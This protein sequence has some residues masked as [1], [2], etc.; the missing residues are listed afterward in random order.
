MTTK[1]AQPVLPASRVHTIVDTLFAEDLHAARGRSFANAATGVLRAD[2]LGAHAIGRGLVA[3]RAQRRRRGADRPAVLPLVVL[4]DG[5]RRRVPQRAALA[6]ILVHQRGS[7]PLANRAQRDA[8]QSEKEERND[9]DGTKQPPCDATLRAYKAEQSHGIP[10]AVP[11]NWKNDS[12]DQGITGS[13]TCPQRAGIRARCCL[14][15]RI[16]WR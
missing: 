9:R 3:E 2:A 7:Q 12:R 11:Y 10:P 15:A 1:I 8:S 6:H 4:G 5:F 13:S 14:G 16:L